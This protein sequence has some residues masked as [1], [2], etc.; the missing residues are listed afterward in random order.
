[1][2]RKG[3]TENGLLDEDEREKEEEEGR[4]KLVN[5]SV[6]FREYGW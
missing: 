2:G 6:C 3:S 4:R 5:E 1:M